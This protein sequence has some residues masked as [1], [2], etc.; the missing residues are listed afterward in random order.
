MLCPE[1]AYD[2]QYNFY[3]KWWAHPRSSVFTF[4]V[5]VF[6]VEF[7]MKKLSEYGVSGL[8]KIFVSGLKSEVP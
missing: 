7:R 1:H 2:Q 3:V 4:D 8:I 5:K 6:A